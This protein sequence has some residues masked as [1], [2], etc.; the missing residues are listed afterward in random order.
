VEDRPRTPNALQPDGSWAPVVGP[1]D[2]PAEGTKADGGGVDR[3]PQTHEEWT[4][5][6]ALPAAERVVAYL[7]SLP[8]AL[9]LLSA[10]A[11]A[12]G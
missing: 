9:V 12:A 6:A 10:L 11:F 5:F 4:A 1:D 7:R 2:D 8:T 3:T